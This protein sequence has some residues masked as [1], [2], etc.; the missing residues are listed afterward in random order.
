MAMNKQQAKDA[1]LSMV[2]IGQN[3]YAAM[4][5][6][7]ERSGTHNESYREVYRQYLAERYR[8]AGFLWDHYGWEDENGFK[9]F[10]TASD[11]AAKLCVGD[12]TLENFWPVFE[13]WFDC[14]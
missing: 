14:A 10:G 3:A 6:V 2:G 9:M 12:E 13:T 4:A 1:I 8:L 7:E 11:M 5:Q